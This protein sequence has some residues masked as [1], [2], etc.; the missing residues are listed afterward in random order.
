M[1][2]PDD[3]VVSGWDISDMN[4]ADCMER[5]CV[6][7]YPLQQKLRPYLQSVTPMKAI[8]YPEFI[9]AN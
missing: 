2:N 6:F 8:Y 3:I 5:A 7:D 9:A 1:V 4:L